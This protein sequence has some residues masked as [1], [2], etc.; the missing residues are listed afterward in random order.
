MGHP[1]TGYANFLCTGGSYRGW[2]SHTRS[3]RVRHLYLRTGRRSSSGTYTTPSWTPAGG[4]RRR[5]SATSPTWPSRPPAATRG[6]PTSDVAVC[7]WMSPGLLPTQTTPC[8]VWEAVTGVVDLTP[9]GSIPRYFHLTRSKNG[10]LE[11]MRSPL[12][13][14]LSV[15]FA[16]PVCPGR[17]VSFPSHME[18]EFG[19]FVTGTTGLRFPVHVHSLQ[20]LC[21]SA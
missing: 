7:P 8:R 17:D 1:G 21:W 16:C 3:R 2:E 12:Y 11:G 20:W 4:A 14:V 10:V 13:S 19:V 6:R 18:Y 15:P 5:S 9:R